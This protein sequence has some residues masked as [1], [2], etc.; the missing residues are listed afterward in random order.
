MS[1]MESKYIGLANVSLHLSWLRMFFKDIGLIQRDPNDLYCNNQGALT[2]CK[3]PEYCAHTKH[4]QQKYH[5]IHDDVVGK[6]LAIVWY[7]PTSEMVVDILT[8]A[9]SHD[10]HSKFTATIGLQPRLSG[11]VRI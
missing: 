3:N 11:S 2:V 4:I 5:S 1:W 9:L 6:G 7:I 8:K 10:K